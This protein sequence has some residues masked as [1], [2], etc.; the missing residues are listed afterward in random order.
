MADGSCG[1]AEL[2][3]D[4]DGNITEYLVGMEAE[5]GIVFYVDSTG[6]HGLVAAME[7][8]PGT[9]VFGC[10]CTYME[11]WTYH[12]NRVFEFIRII[13]RFL[14]QS[15]IA[16]TGALNY[17]TEGYNDWY[18]PSIDELVEIYNTIAQGGSEG[19]IGGF[20]N[21]FYWSSTGQNNQVCWDTHNCR[22]YCNS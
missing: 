17:E 10:W 21:N 12:W 9:Y 18:L 11:W 2:G 7:D 3:Y 8:L 13:S 20:E 19:N 16:A 22:K 6:Q 14:R 5:G 1:Y 4:C 15:P